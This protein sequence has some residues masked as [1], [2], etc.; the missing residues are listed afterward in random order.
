[1]HPLIGKTQP[2]WKISR[3][4]PALSETGL[5]RYDTLRRIA[6]ARYNPIIPP[7]LTS[8]NEQAL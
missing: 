7:S 1:V 8:V 2:L 3:V 4:Y 5:P 6:N